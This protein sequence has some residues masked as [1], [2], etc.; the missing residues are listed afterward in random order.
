MLR[1]HDV[2]SYVKLET[3]KKI[4]LYSNK[5]PDV[6]ETEYVSAED[7]TGEVGKLLYLYTSKTQFCLS[8]FNNFHYLNDFE[9]CFSIDSKYQ[10]A[11]IEKK[12]EN[13]N[14]QFESGYFNNDKNDTYYLIPRSDGLFTPFYLIKFGNISRNRFLPPVEKI[15]MQICEEK[16][17]LSEKFI[18]IMGI[19][20]FLDVKMEPGKKNRIINL[21][22]KME[23]YQDKK[24][25]LVFDNIEMSFWKNDWIFGQI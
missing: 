9:L 12:L 25:N 19:R 23:R 14:F 1:L 10:I 15:E 7:H 20:D 24:I 8:P 11:D 21:T 13:N 6:F 16:L 18:E 3:L 2:T 5:N 17:S 22:L 4:E